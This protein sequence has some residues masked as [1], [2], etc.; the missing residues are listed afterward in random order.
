MSKNNENNPISVSIHL[1][2]LTTNNTLLPAMYLP[3]KSRLVS[4]HLINGA[5]ISA[6]DSN[7]FQV[8]L[9]N[10]ATV[11]AEMDSRAAHENGVTANVAKALNMVADE[12]DQEA[13]SSLSLLYNEAGTVALTDAKLV[14]TYFPY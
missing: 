7:Y 14:L 4:A 10:G 12:Q 9:K 6:H 5:T 13:G 1:G 11:L 2:S 3:K 8:A